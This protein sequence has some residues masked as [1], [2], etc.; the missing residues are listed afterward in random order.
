VASFTY[1]V[2]GSSVPITVYFSNTSTNATSWLWN[3]GDGTISTVQNPSHIYSTAGD[4]TVKLIASGAVNTDSTLQIL[5]VLNQPTV[6]GF[7]YSFSGSSLPVTVNFSN[8]STNATG[9]VWNFGDGTTSTVQ[10][11]S[12]IYSTAGDYTV[13]LIAS[14][15]INTDSTSQIVHVL[16]QANDTYINLTL[17]GTNYSWAPNVISGKYVIDSVSSGGLRKYTLIEGQ[18]ANYIGFS[19]ENGNTTLPG[20]YNVYI[21]FII[22]GKS[23]SHNDLITTTCTAYGTV[24][25][26]IIGS[27][28][29]KVFEKSDTATKIP[30]SLQY[31]VTRIQ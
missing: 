29:G 27:A 21:G 4:Y 22:N 31:K 13:K 14:G 3:F 26:Y 7:T 18:N 15:A 11:P 19:F 8:T 28:S 30:F 25:G 16:F 24:G 10:N 6:A 17:N 23:Y 12:H 20:S 9:W 5:H 1:S 2:S